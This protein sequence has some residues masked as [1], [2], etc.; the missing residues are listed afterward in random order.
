[1]ENR[2]IWLDCIGSEDTDFW[3]ELERQEDYEA[4]KE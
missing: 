4:N 2:N 3:D 1:M